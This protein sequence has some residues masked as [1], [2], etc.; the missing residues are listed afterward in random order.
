MEFFENNAWVFII[1][2][3]IVVFTAIYF[4]EKKRTQEL[5]L[6]ADNMGFFFAETCSDHAGVDLKSFEL[7]SRGRS[8]TSKNKIWKKDDLSE[9]SIFEYS[10]KS[11]SGK[12][13]RKHSQTVLSIKSSEL[14]A[15]NFSL[16]PERTLHKIGKLVGFQ[17][18]DFAAFPDFSNKYLLR[19][20]NVERITEFFTPR[21]I[22][23]F[24]D[25]ALCTIEVREGVFI[26]FKPLKRYKPDEIKAFY[27][28]GQQVFDN[29]IN[30]A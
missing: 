9:I 24:E 1:I 25:N 16:K 19:G 26:F 20:K 15:P 27:Q 4:Y 22:R 18:I 30:N 13:S 3:V 8:K 21:L 23:F 14:V 28:D 29:L 12:N 10:Y 11:G 2:V 5:N 6:V 7:F 17:D